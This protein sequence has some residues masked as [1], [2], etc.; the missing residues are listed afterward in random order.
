MFFQ[1]QNIAD[2]QQDPEPVLTPNVLSTTRDIIAWSGR[3][4]IHD[5]IAPD[6][7]NDKWLDPELKNE[8]RNL[9]IFLSEEEGEMNFFIQNKETNKG[10]AEA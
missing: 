4:I 3:G 6:N 1:D 9:E 5:C 2:P 10:L 7:S 8:I